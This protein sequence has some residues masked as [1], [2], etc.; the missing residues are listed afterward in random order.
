MKLIL[1]SISPPPGAIHPHLNIDQKVKPEFPQVM[2][3][4]ITLNQK[5]NTTL[6]SSF[7]YTGTKITM[8]YR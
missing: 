8:S 7:V 1:L 5:P 4:V 2:I 3:F 6:C